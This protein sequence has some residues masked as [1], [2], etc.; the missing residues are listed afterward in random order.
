MGTFIVV[1]CEEGSKNRGFSREMKVKD[2][3]QNG[4]KKK[5]KKI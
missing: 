2:K 5:V 4:T 3:I 1:Y